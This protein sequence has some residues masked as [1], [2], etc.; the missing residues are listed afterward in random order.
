MSACDAVLASTD[1][2]DELMVWGLGAWDRHRPS[3]EFTLPRK[4]RCG[5]SQP[6]P[7]RPN[8]RAA[9]GG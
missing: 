8:G 1:L 4:D 5:A 2:V 3:Y 6:T 9:L 7:A